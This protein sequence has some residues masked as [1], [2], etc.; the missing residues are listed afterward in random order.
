MLLR[1]TGSLFVRGRCLRRLAENV[2]RYTWR[3]PKSV[4][5]LSVVLRVFAMDASLF[6][7]CRGLHLKMSVDKFTRGNC[8]RYVRCVLAQHVLQSGQ[9]LL[10]AVCLLVDMQQSTRYAG[11]D[12]C[13]SEFPA[14]PQ[15]CS[16]SSRL[17]V[18]ERLPEATPCEVQSI[19][20]VRNSSRQ[21]P[22]PD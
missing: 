12:S 1:R 4:L 9:P 3:F 11:S 14:L 15:Q 2:A 7:V 22:G 10:I 13:V 5:N 20:A 6:A 17:P 8:P 18:R 19:G 16:H 21:Q